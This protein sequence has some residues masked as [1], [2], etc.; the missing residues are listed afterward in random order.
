M[1]IGWCDSVD[2]LMKL[3]RLTRKIRQDKTFS[4]P[5]SQSKHHSMIILQIE[6]EVLD[7]NGWKRAF[8]SDPINR[9]QSGVRHHTI[10]RLVNSPNHVIIELAFDNTKDAELMLEALK[11]LWNKV[12]GKVMV[13]PQA[14]IIETVERT[15]Y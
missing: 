3:A 5:D 12:E 9:K 14:R 7:F 4:L 8:D 2:K 15:T 6:H 1:S 13:S 10:S 11:K